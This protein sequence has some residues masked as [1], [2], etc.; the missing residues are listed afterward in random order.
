MPEGKLHHVSAGG[1]FAVW[2]YA[3]EAWSAKPF[4]VTPHGFLHCAQQ[5]AAAAQAS[6]QTSTT[7]QHST[8]LLPEDSACPVDVQKHAESE[9]VA[10]VAI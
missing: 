4:C 2:H 9:N 3:C 8:R 6:S 10:L 7:E 5:I 1:A